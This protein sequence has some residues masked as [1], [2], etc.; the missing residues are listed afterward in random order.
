[1]KNNAKIALKV[2][3]IMLAL[4]CSKKYICII[5]TLCTFDILYRNIFF[6]IVLYTLSF[7]A[8]DTRG[9]YLRFAGEEQFCF[10]SIC[11]IN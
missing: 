4:T 9:L 8:I 5:D 3:Y 11:L 6:L 1:M 10:G 2:L 7:A